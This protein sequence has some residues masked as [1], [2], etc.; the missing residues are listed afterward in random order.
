MEIRYSRLIEEASS[1]TR[2]DAEYFRRD[3]LQK[4]IAIQSKGFLRIDE[5]AF[6]T[7][8]I[9]SSIEF[10]DES[11]VNLISAKSPKE[12]FFDLS[13]NHYI[14][15][16]QHNEN[17]RTALLENDVIVSTVGTIGNC[18]VVRNDMLPANS[19]RHVGIIRI[20]DSNIIQPYFL[21]S[22][23][24]SKYGRFQTTRETTGNVQPNLF[25]YKIKDLIVPALSLHF[26]TII[27]EFCKEAFAL[28]QQ[29]KTTYTT[30]ENI[31]LSEIGLTDFTPSN[32]PVNIK[33]FKESFATSGR[34]DAEY[35]SMQSESVIKTITQGKYGAVPLH[36]IC[37]TQRGNLIPDTYYCDAGTKYIRGAD[38]S[39]NCLTDTGV[40]I[41]SSFQV[42]NETLTER[43][44]IVFALIGSV[45]KLAL[46]TEGFVGSFISNNIGLMRFIHKDFLPE[47][48]HLFLTSKFGKILF[49][50]VEMRT[51][52]PK[53]SDKDIWDFPIPALDITYQQQIAALI[54]Q[55]FALKKQS[56]H[57]LEVAKRAVE[58]AIEQD[59]AAAMAWIAAHALPA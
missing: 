56:E 7:D 47:Y 35:Y 30:A 50:K 24:L 4:K 54:T 44:D 13:S 51:A 52:Q 3:Y 48:V 36:A 34:L 58:I 6:V 26:Q 17:P 49:D 23:L 19:D 11:T 1:K 53:I 12:N 18:A 33:T 59:E 45:G 40:S 39:A 10:C 8:G 43:G 15:T 46:V 22:F 42:R 38:F 31:L 28:Q 2:I 9:H 27:Q 14:S 37:K 16:K 41:D 57:L 55:S 5:F 32:D 29:S 25:I 20:K 21:S